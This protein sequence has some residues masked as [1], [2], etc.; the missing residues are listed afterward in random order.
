MIEDRLKQLVEKY[1]FSL[2]GPLNVN[3]LLSGTK[4]T[5]FFSDFG[6]VNEYLSLGLVFNR[7]TQ[8]TEA[9]REVPR[10]SED[11][12]LGVYRSGK[13]NNYRCYNIV[14]WSLLPDS[15]TGSR[16]GVSVSGT[17]NFLRPSPINLDHNLHIEPGS[18]A[19]KRIMEEVKKRFGGTRSFNDLQGRIISWKKDQ[20]QKFPMECKTDYAY[21]ETLW[22]IEPYISRI[23]KHHMTTH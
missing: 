20:A 15:G 19:A 3:H 8:P 13:L 14:S 11:L 12:C 21:V 5:V 9:N 17:P 22:G 2:D 18:P 16:L 23:R 6:L 4:E 10:P 7:F 1:G